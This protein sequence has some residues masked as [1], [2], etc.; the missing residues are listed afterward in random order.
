MNEPPR[1]QADRALAVD[2]GGTRRKTPDAAAS[3]PLLRGGSSHG[4]PEAH[5]LDE[6]RGEEAR[7]AE[8]ARAQDSRE[9]D[10]RENGDAP[11]R[12]ADRDEARSQESTSREI[13]AQ[14]ECGE[15][16]GRN[17]AWRCTKGVIGS[18]RCER[19]P[20]DRDAEDRHLAVPM[21]RRGDPRRDWQ[22]LE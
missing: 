5:A 15:S 20:H 11:I 4:D 9:E 17:E 12:E 19:A 21:W 8:P 6:A 14:G 10:A 18:A 2:R 22:G 3:R 7:S 1:R 13:G 16:S